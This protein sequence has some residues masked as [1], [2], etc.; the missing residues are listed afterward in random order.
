MRCLQADRAL[1]TPSETP[2]GKHHRSTEVL[3]RSAESHLPEGQT[4]EPLFKILITWN[5]LSSLT[6]LSCLVSAA[7]S[8]PR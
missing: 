2:E 6:G 1:G 7:C 5:R 4:P 3:P 8:H